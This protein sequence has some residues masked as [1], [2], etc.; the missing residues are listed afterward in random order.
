MLPFHAMVLFSG[1]KMDA[2]DIM[3]KSIVIW[4]HSGFAIITLTHHSSS[5][6]PSVEAESRRLRG[7]NVYVHT[8]TGIESCVTG[9]VT[10]ACH[11]DFAIVYLN[12][13]SHNLLGSSHKYGF[14]HHLVI[15][16]YL[17]GNSLTME[18]MWLCKWKC[19]Y[20]LRIELGNLPRTFTKYSS[21]NCL[22]QIQLMRFNVRTWLPSFFII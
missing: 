14:Y 8:H 6:S 11:Y 19:N 5:S 18:L 2:L 12:I 10:N 17:E 1:P 3:Q 15:S 13:W 16:P 7:Q 22:R 21:N 9:A 20:L 4:W